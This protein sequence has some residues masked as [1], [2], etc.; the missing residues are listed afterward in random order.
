ERLYAAFKGARR[1]I[2]RKGGGG[3]KIRLQEA[4][5]SA[6]PGLLAQRRQEVLL[7]LLLNHPGLLGEFA[8]DFVDLAL[9]VPELDRLLGEILKVH[10]LFPGL[11]ANDLRRH[12]TEKGW[13][14][15]VERVL[16]PRVLNH[17]A[18]AR[19]DA[20]AE[21]VREGWIHT[22]G[23]FQHGLLTKQIREAER[24]LTQDMTDE[25]WARLQQTVVEG[26]NGT[27]DGAEDGEHR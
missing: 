9:A 13:A 20:E 25:N 24:D 19:V 27:D 7:A 8:E 26:K 18:F 15:T 23:Q 4:P 5:P 3:Q 11:D 14:G 6:D 10:A 1:A 21:R 12:L 2:G 22:R 16:S 17:A